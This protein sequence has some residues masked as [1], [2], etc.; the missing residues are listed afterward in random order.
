LSPDG[1]ITS[2]KREVID[3]RPQDFKIFSL[4]EIKNLFGKN[5]L[6]FYSGFGNRSTVIK[7]YLLLNKIGCHCL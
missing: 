3:R 1:L 2:F 7:I 4:T 6:P 5:A